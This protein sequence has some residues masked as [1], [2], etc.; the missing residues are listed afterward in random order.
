MLPDGSLVAGR[1]RILGPVG[2][3]RSGV[4]YRADDRGVSEVALKVVDEPNEARAEALLIAATRAKRLRLRGVVRTIDAGRDG[5]SVWV[6]CELIEGKSLAATIEDEGP[7]DATRTVEILLAL[8]RTLD[9][10]HKTGLLHGDLKPENVVITAG[11]HPVLTDLGLARSR[12][13]GGGAFASP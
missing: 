7:L 9:A 6:A 12:G 5:A 8:C 4:V 11:G 2:A 10:V 1:F 3:G 13:A